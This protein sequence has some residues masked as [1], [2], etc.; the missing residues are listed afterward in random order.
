MAK[1]WEKWG[2]AG[3]TQVYVIKSG[4][5]EPFFAFGKSF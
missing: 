5:N 2:K 3:K 1:K 4:E